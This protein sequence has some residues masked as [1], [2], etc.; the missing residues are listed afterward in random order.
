MNTYTYISILFFLC[1]ISCSRT[2]YLNGKPDQSLIIPET[3]EDFQAILDN[4]EIMNGT[5]GAGAQQRTTGLL[6]GF[7]E[8]GA[9]DYYC[10]ENVIENNQGTVLTYLL[11]WNDDI[12]GSSWRISDWQIAYRP[13]FYANLVL[14]KLA[15]IE[16][17][18]NNSINYDR[19]MG[20]AY[21]YRAYMFFHLAQVYAP[22]YVPDELGGK[23]GIPLRLTADMDERIFRATLDETYQQILNDLKSA[24]PLLPEKAPVS[25]RPSK[26]AVHGMLAKVY[27]TMHNYQEAYHYADLSLNIT[28]ALL[29]YNTLDTSKVYP[30]PFFKNND[31]II[32]MSNLAASNSAIGSI[33]YNATI[34]TLLLKQYEKGD[35]RRPLYY[36]DAAPMWGNSGMFFQGSLNGNSSYRFFSGIT[37]G[38][39][40][41]IRAECRIR[42]GSIAEGLNDL[43]QLLKSRFE[44]SFL[45]PYEEQDQ[46][47]ALE[48]VFSERRKELV[49]RGLRW[50]DLRRLNAEG[51]NITISREIDGVRYTLAADDPRWTYLIPPDVI[52]FNP[53]M[54]QNLR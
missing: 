38:E 19:I 29:D 4:D 35:L 21:Y 44:P 11:T 24:L 6:P 48:T 30:F 42:Q 39:L 31:E 17:S 40:L 26:A 33:V 54:P 7:L 5:E 41:L 8:G 50:Q 53:D 43:H 52:G 16:R 2:D 49:M 20:S 36:R 9:D 51:R 32:F 47:A 46:Q 27:L 13:V 28:S 18:E 34:D 25:T 15:G 12:Y 14:E 22:P 45:E 10:R 3:L 1:C 37:S 23:W